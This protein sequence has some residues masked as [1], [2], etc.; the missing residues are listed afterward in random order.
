MRRG[1]AALVVVGC[2]GVPAALPATADSRSRSA[3]RDGMTLTASPAVGLSASEASVRV[4]GTGYDVN[5]GIYVAFC[6][7][8]GPGKVPS[9]CGGG[10]DRDGSSGSSVWVS[11]FPPYYGTGLAQ[12]YGQGGTFDVTLRVQAQLAEDVD[13]RRVRCAV[14]TRADHTA[15][16][17]RTLDVA[18]PVEF[19]TPRRAATA[20]PRP[21]HVGPSRAA[22][23]ATSAPAARATAPRATARPTPAGT[24]T[25]TPT[26]A[27]PL[28]PA[29][30]PALTEAAP[31]TDEGTSA[32][33]LLGLAGLGLAG[34]AGTTF[35]L[36]RRRSR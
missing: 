17:D 2:V 12:P 34:A 7:D 31:T 26:L 11:S 36:R 19:T 6:V 25:A 13:C 23:T 32:T 1:L 4:T 28:L 30:E 35:A 10:Q 21:P 20:S 8:N 22:P 3:T 16:D 5:R 18:V 24:P 15:S 29:E 33:P 9:P 14:V 27:R